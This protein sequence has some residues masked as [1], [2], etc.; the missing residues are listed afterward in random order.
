MEARPLSPSKILA[1]AE[2][3]ELTAFL[4]Y[5]YVIASRAPRKSGYRVVKTKGVE[6]LLLAVTE[7]FCCF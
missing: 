7:K 3:S 4:R 6:E 2:A 1:L 5:V